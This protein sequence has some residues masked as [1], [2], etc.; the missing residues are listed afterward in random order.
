MVQRPTL[1]VLLA[2][3]AAGSAAA[4]DSQVAPVKQEQR[5]D[6]RQAR[7]D[8]RITQGVESGNLTR[9]E[10]FRLQRQQKAI[11]HREARVEADGTVT[12]KEAIGLEHAQD[13]ASR[14]IAHARHDRQV[15][16]QRAAP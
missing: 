7:Q 4:Q 16:G 6:N 12:R 10:Q 8:D 9:R 15:R 5:V 11:E 14:T 13:R 2:L 3:L 1:V